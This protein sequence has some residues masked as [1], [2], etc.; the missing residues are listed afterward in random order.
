MGL[1]IYRDEFG[2]RFTSPEGRGRFA[3]ANRVRGYGLSKVLRPLTRIA[4]QS[5]LSPL[6]RGGSARGYGS[7]TTYASQSLYSAR[8]LALKIL[9]RSS[10]VSG[11]L[12]AKRGSSK[13][14]CG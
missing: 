9:R 12:K 8:A 7:S 6:G 3:L 1:T 13:S 5:D 10:S 14:Q 11:V 2:R 4:A